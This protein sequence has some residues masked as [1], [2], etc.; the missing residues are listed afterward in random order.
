MVNDIARINMDS[1]QVAG[2][3]LATPPPQVR[4][5]TQNAAALLSS[6]RDGVHTPN[7][8]FSVLAS[9]KDEAVHVA[10][11]V[12]E[13]AR[14]LQEM[15]TTIRAM[16]ERVMVLVKSYPPFPAGSEER[17]NYLRSIAA[18]KQQLEAMSFPPEGEGHE[19][20]LYPRELN[21]P[22]LYPEQASD[23]DFLRFSHRLDQLGQEV[24]AGLGQL[25][26]MVQGLPSWGTQA[27]SAANA[28]GDAGQ[29]IT[30]AQQTTRQLLQWP[31]TILP[32]D[33]PLALIGG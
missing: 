13:A 2:G 29:A 22:D 12:R 21:L 33:A 15:D 28:N 25:R 3:L 23:E 27:G 32:H 26:S 31:G 18:L 1:L 11:A 4:L 6:V 19:P 14:V 7:A 16:Q 8:A 10:Q 9:I 20:V 24:V 17:L 30:L 5:K